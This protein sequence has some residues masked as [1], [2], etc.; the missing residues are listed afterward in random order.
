M[1]TKTEELGFL[2]L[3]ARD[4]ARVLPFRAHDDVR[5]YLNGISVEPLET[6]GT[7]L[8]ATNGHMLAAVL[9]KESHATQK[10]I[11]DTP[12]ALEA[13]VRKA[14]KS[15]LSYVDLESEKSRLEV[16]DKT[17]KRFAQQ[18]SYV[19]PGRALVDG[20]Y[21]EWRKIIDGDSDRSCAS[22]IVLAKAARR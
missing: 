19:K 9:S 10:V 2:R 15:E 20:K 3:N 14:A 1:A 4:L 13:A 11:I 17:G 6:G 21:P 5:Y 8:V 22:S 12:A 7:I 16:I 18:C